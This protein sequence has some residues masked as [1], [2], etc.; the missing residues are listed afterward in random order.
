M[1]AVTVGDA[2]DGLSVAE[3]DC[4]RA[5][6]GLSDEELAQTPLGEARGAAWE[7][8][9]FECLE[10]G[11]VIVVASAVN[12]RLFGERR[13]ETRECML[14][15]HREYPY[16]LRSQVGLNPG[17][18]LTD[19]E[20]KE[21]VAG[22]FNCMTAVEQ[23]LWIVITWR[24]APGFPVTTQDILGFIT[25]EELACS[26]ELLGDSLTPESAQGPALS[27]MSE[28]PELIGC[29]A[30]DR[31]AF[32]FVEFMTRRFGGVSMDSAACMTDT[33]IRLQDLADTPLMEV[34]E[35]RL[36]PDDE[37]EELMVQFTEFFAC[38]TDDEFLRFER[39][40]TNG[41]L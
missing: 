3:A 28:N 4:A 20:V 33:M 1:S 18:P 36:L 5:A 40:I 8:P 19:A 10:T 6:S 24:E 11:S 41:L 26:I 23:A 13:P 29:F 9:V 38:L 21:F 37:A 12:D 14:E 31:V 30:P 15:W 39:M 34:A 25:P 16:T 32:L 35:L 27:V 2:L 17:E 7:T 22:I